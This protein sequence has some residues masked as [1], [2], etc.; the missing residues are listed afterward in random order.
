VSKGLLF[1]ELWLNRAC[2]ARIKEKSGCE[3]K[4]AALYQ[5]KIMAR[6]NKNY[7]KQENKRKEKKP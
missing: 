3:Q 1:V 5:Q 7:R 2:L 4:P 6:E